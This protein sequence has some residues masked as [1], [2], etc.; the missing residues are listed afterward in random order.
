[1]SIRAHLTCILHVV[2]EGIF[3]PNRSSTLLL[4]R[5]GVCYMLVLVE[6]NQYES[7]LWSKKVLEPSI[8]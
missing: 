1:M 2:F 3:A 7:N 5:T 8:V 6:S 4:G